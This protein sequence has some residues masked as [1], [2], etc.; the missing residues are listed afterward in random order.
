MFGLLPQS[1]RLSRIMSSY[2]PL[3]ELHLCAKIEEA[4]MDKTASVHQG[5]IYEPQTPS[6]VSNGGF[7]VKSRIAPDTLPL[8]S[9]RYSPRE[10]LLL[11]SMMLISMA[12]FLV[13]WLPRSLSAPAPTNL[14]N[15]DWIPKTQAAVDALQKWYNPNTGLWET[16]NWWNAAN[17]LTMLGDFALLNPAFKSQFEKIAQTT[18]R[19]APGFKGQILKVR[20]PTSIDTYTYPN[21]PPG[22]QAPPMVNNNDGFLNWYYDDEGWWALA[23]LKAYDVTNQTIYLKEAIVIFDDM[24]KGY[25]AKCGGIWWNKG[26]EANV[27]ISNEL[28]LAVAA[29][30]ANRVE[31]GSKKFYVDW[32]SLHWN[33]FRAAGFINKDYNINDGLDLATCK[34]N[35]GTIWSYNQGVILGALAEANATGEYKPPANGYAYHY[36]ILAISHSALKKLEDA[37]GIIH[38]ACEPDCGNDGPQFKGIFMRNLQAVRDFWRRGIGSSAESEAAIARNAASIWNKDRNEDDKLGLVWSGPYVEATAATQSSALD[39]LVAAI[40]V[41]M[42]PAPSQVVTSGRATA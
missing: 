11:L 25:N 7:T 10:I 36:F 32:V 30:L 3:D 12:L 8:S 17:I 16:T 20:T 22:L 15:Q 5:Y 21:I 39:A 40:D 6:H 19:K 28:F 29:Q 34:N 37:N 38:D 1:F 26:H 41:E 27:A 33:W 13:Y 35:N 24:I 9:R 31:A 4:V 14:T 42:H 2:A 23:W 18:H